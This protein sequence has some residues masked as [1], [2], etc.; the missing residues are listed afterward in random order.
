[1]SDEVRVEKHGP[2]TTVILNRPEVRNAVDPKTGA[3]LVGRSSPSPPVHEARRRAFVNA[4]AF[5][6]GSI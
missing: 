1:M 2:V 5:R 4:M 3:E 6:H